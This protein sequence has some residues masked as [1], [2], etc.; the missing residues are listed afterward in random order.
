MAV[1]PSVLQADSNKIHIG[2]PVTMEVG[3]LWFD[4]DK[5]RTLSERIET[6]A[7]YY[8]RKYGRDASICYLNP[9]GDQMDLPVS[10]G[11]IRILPSKTILP[12]HFWI[13]IGRPA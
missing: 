12:N 5:K 4:N 3:M 8:H 9:R 2:E 1:E 11:E 13:G 6:A 7:E 10:V